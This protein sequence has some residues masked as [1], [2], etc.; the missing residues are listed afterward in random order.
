MATDA[1]A[2]TSRAITITFPS[3]LGVLSGTAFITKFKVGDAA[4]DGK[5]PFSASVKI[6][7]VPTFTVTA[8]T[9]LTTPFF[10]VSG[11]G[12]VIVPTA[13]GSVYDYVVNIGTAIG[14]V[15]IT[16]TATAGVITITAN[17]VSQVVSTGVASTAITLGVA[18]S[19]VEA[20]IS[21]AETGK[22]PKVYTLQLTR[23]A[24]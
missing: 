10:T 15:T 20:V 19:I 21:V 8:S 23:A 4:F 9:G 18:G 24:S 12:T 2:R 13:S 1:A 14:T 16:P 3:S 6:T 11:A 17:D 22:T 7:G 5:I